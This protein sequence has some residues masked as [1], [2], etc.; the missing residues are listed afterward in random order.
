MSDPKTTIE[1]YLEEWRVIEAELHYLLR[2]RKREEE[3]PGGGIADILTKKIKIREKTRENIEW[4]LDYLPPKDGFLIRMLY[5]ENTTHRE[6]AKI[7]N[8]SERQVYREKTRI[9]QKMQDF[10][11]NTLSKLED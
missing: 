7:L 3:I 11:D 4:M 9:L 1:R 8:V 5:L 2:E 6:A 10:Y